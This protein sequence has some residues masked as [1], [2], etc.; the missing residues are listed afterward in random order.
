MPRTARV[1]LPE[2]PHHVIQ[3]G[4]NRASVFVEPADFMFYL[5]TLAEWK[6]AL[7]CKVYAYCLMTN[8]V[9]LVIDPGESADNLALLMKRVAGRYTRYVNRVE[10]RS[11]TVWNGRYK[12]SPIETDRYLM[13]CSRYIE[14]NPVRARIASAPQDYGWSSYNH[15]I[16]RSRVTWLDE[17]PCYAS[18]GA[19]R[20]ERESRYREWV[21]STVP[22]GEWDLIR[23]AVQRG[24]LSGSQRFREEIECR[25]ARRVESRGPGRPA[26]TPTRAEK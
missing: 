17:D 9:H 21:S 26:R 19:Q 15:K 5:D 23:L 6:N 20:F 12:S 14:L 1:V 11:G 16:G 13:A 22:E 8:H 25:L 3:R 4:H 7:G 18:L 24:Q 2:H 10:R